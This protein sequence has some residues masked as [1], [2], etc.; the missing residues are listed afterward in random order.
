MCQFETAMT[1]MN[2]GCLTVMVQICVDAQPT[3]HYCSSRYRKYADVH[4]SLVS[5]SIKS[6]GYPSHNVT[7]ALPPARSTIASS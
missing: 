3:P 7:T 6:V 1:A 4:N 2:L 5:G